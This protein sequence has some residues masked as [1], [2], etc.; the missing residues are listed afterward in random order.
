[1]RKMLVVV[2]A[3]M[4][5]LSGCA[6]AA[7]K[8]SFEA[9]GLRNQITVLESQLT[10]KEQEISELKE[11][12]ALAEAQAVKERGKIFTAASKRHKK[13]VVAEIKSRPNIPCSV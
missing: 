12:L 2:F 7:K 10:S 11:S 9:Q 8:D 6:T 5:L 3:V 4:V 1:M 13:R